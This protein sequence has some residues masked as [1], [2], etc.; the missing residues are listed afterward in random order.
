MMQ[1]GNG[2]SGPLTDSADA[3]RLYKEALHYLKRREP[4]MA[5][6]VLNRA[7]EAKP[8]DPRFLSCL[9]LC[10]AMVDR[11]SNEALELCEKALAAGV[12]GDFFYCNLGK[13]HL[14]RG[15]KQKAYAAFK[16]GLKTNPRNR[17][18]VRELRAM[19]VRHTAFF[20]FLPRGHFINRFAGRMLSMLRRSAV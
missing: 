1:H 6:H 10:K 11:R 19:G 8:G 7:L 13:V 3:E 16:A 2:R 5:G 4:N 15:N 17:D 14:L 9:G 18:I 20:A 12:Y